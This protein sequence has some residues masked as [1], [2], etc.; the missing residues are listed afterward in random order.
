M[1]SLSCSWL[2]LAVDGVHALDA[3][4]RVA[5]VAGLARHG[6]VGLRLEA[7]RGTTEVAN[8]RYGRV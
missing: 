6:S 2:L 3:A 1:T 5:I 7:E 8:V 4:A